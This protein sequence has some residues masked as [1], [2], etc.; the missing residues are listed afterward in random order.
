M[1]MKFTS[2]AICVLVAFFQMLSFIGFA[3]NAQYTIPNSQTYKRLLESKFEGF[4]IVKNSLYSFNYLPITNH[5]KS[6]EQELLLMNHRL[7]IFL[8]A[9]GIVYES[10]ENAQNQDSL[11]FKRIDNTEHTGYNIDCVPFIYENNLY[12]IG[13]YG[14]WRCNGQLRIFDHKMK[15]WNLIP[16][17]QEIPVSK[18]V[19]QPLIWQNIPNNEIMILAYME[20]NEAVITNNQSPT[21]RADSVMSLNLKTKS[22]QLKGALNQELAKTLYDTK[23]LANL[24]SGLLV[25]NVGKIQYWNLVSN[26]VY[27]LKNASTNQL[28]MVAHFITNLTWK[29]GNKLIIGN[30]ANQSIIDS[31]VVNQKDFELTEQLIFVPPTPIKAYLIAFFITTIIVV[32]LVFRIRISKSKSIKSSTLN[33]VPLIQS[34]S[35]LNSSYP[36][37]QLF[38]IT[39]TD[40][41]RLIIK[42]AKE[43]Q[44]VTNVDEINRVLGVGNKSLDMQKR[45]RSDVIKNINERYALATNREAVVLINRMKSEIDGRLYEFYIPE[46]ELKNVIV[47][48]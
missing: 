20:G 25:D 4:R 15:E 46:E 48:L 2:K 45:K 8:N 26:K 38:S 14:F 28:L 12:N 3:Q 16:L 42:N 29:E 30:L 11:Y 21:H 18:Y 44:R 43:H 6:Y 7:Y 39:E 24:D 27:K 31:V 34:S 22:W 47:Y 17:N 9:S 10:Q 41:L 5:F 23:F 35:E 40:L 36:K 37:P 13:G 19:N 1:N 32:I 33:S